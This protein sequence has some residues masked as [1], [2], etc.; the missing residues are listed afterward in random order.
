[1]SY[2]LEKLGNYCWNKR[3]LLVFIGKRYEDF[4]KLLKT[5]FFRL[6]EPFLRERGRYGHAIG[7]INNKTTYCIIIYYALYINGMSFL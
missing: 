5:R 7:L 3:L 6:T 4:K 1:M 2:K